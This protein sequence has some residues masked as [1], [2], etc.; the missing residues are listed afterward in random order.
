MLKRFRHSTIKFIKKYH[1][2]L[3]MEVLMKKHVGVLFSLLAIAILFV[4]FS[5]TAHAF[6]VG[7]RGYYWFPT[8]KSDMKVNGAFQ[9]GTEFNLKDNLGLGFKPYPSVE[10]FGGLG[11]HNLSLMYTQANY[12]GSATLSSEIKFHGTV[13]SA[14]TPVDSNL[15]LRVLD[16]AYKYNLINMENILAGFSV[17]PIVKIKYIEGDTSITSSTAT[18]SDKFRLPIPMVGMGAHAGI[19]LNILEA[20]AEITG[21][22]YSGN[23]LYEAFGDLSL[24]PFPLI[25]INGGYKIIK[26]HVDHGDTYFNAD[27]AGPY[28]ALT[29]KF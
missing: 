1:Y 9:E 14:N 18:S 17:G 22:A 15:K 28:V 23:Y 8:M 10:V 13:F 5:N 7:V 16:L 24:T 20:R 2:V 27:F 6:Q 12:S 25:D 21:T 19:L 4:T 26:I 11:K 29:V 3:E